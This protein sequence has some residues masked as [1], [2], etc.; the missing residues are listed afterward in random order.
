MLKQLLTS[1]VFLSIINLLLFSS[2]FKSKFFNCSPLSKLINI[3]FPLLGSFIKVIFCFFSGYKVSFEIFIFSS[4]EVKLIFLFIPF[5]SSLFSLFIN[6]IS[7]VFKSI[8]FSIFNFSPLWFNIISFPVFL[9][10]IIFISSSEEEEKEKLISSSKLFS[11][12]LFITYI[13]FWLIGS[14]SILKFTIFSPVIPLIKIG[15]FV[16]L[17]YTFSILSNFSPVF[18]LIKISFPVKLSFSEISSNL[19]GRIFFWFVIIILLFVL[20]SFL[21]LILFISSPVSLLNNLISPV[22]LFSINSKLSNFS[23]V[24]LLIKISFP[25]NLSFIG[26][27]SMNFSSFL[28]FKIKISFPVSLSIFLI[29]SF[30]SSLLSLF[31]NLMSPFSLVSIFILSNFSPVFLFINISFFVLGSFI[32]INSF[33]EDVLSLSFI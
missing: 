31:I 14:F 5:I 10:F 30:I 23:P 27:I 17:L 4:P 29:K 12:L 28:S 8:S 9:S 20:L 2:T 13:S 32:Q 19:L 26:I 33:D 3:S 22:F 18:L 15:S 25:V 21:I 24:F 7:P 11:S 16:I 1:N 6:F